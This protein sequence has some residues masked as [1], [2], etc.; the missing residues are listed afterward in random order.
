V[1]YPSSEKGDPKE[2][3]CG[4]RGKKNVLGWGV[5]KKATGGVAPE[6]QEKE[7]EK[8]GQTFKAFWMLRFD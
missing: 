5:A 3:G 2:K 4:L 8:K 7:V 1:T 6:V